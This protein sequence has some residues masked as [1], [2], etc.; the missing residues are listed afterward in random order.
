MRFLKITYPNN[1]HQYCGSIQEASERLGVHRNSIHNA[2]KSDGR[3]GH[4]NITIED[5]V[6]EDVAKA[7]LEH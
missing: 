6:V 3:L 2:L 7:L 1:T 5:I 4:T